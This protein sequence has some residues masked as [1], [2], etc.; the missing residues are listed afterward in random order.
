MSQRIPQKPKRRRLDYRQDPL[1]RCVHL[2]GLR[3]A[4][5]PPG[6]PA[7]STGTTAPNCLSS[8]HLDDEPGGPGR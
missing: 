3:L 4:G 1:R 2:P 7:P 8:V 5:G 6:P